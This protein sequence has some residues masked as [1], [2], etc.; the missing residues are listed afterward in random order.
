MKKAIVIGALLV[1][2]VGGHVLYGTDA[3][4]L[5]AG[6]TPRGI[7]RLSDDQRQ[8][9]AEIIRLFGF[10]C[11]RLAVLTPDVRPGEYRAHCGPAGGGAYARGYRLRS[12]GETITAVTWAD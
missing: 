6:D 4:A 3:P 8:A 1:L 12:N 11:P 5:R 2:F 10:D 7:D 9:L